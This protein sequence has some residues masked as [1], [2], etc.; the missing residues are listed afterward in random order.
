MEANIN[1]CAHELRQAL[2]YAE[3]NIATLR[4]PFVVLDK[5]LLVRTA[6]AV[7]YRDFHV[8]KEQMEDRFVFDLGNSQWDIPQLRTL[9]PQVLSDSHPVEGLEVEHAFPALGRRNLPFKAHRFPPDGDDADT[10]RHLGG[11]QYE[12]RWVVWTHRPHPSET[13]ARC[14]LAVEAASQSAAGPRVHEAVRV[15]EKLRI[16][17]TRF[18]GVDG[19]TALLRRALALARA[20]V[21]ALRGITKNADGSMQGLEKLVADAGNS[22]VGGATRQSRS[23]PICSGCWLRLSANRSRCAWS[24]A[25]PDASLDE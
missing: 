7:F 21:P 25:W 3:N 20:E 2:V 1:K 10:H 22:G 18:A 15:C 17:L 23:P 19:F 6:N 16:S 8:S 4:E 5:G 12:G 11:S 13:L 14:L 9:L 24:R